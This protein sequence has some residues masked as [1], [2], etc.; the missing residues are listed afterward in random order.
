MIYVH[1]HNLKRKVYPKPFFANFLCEKKINK[2]ILFGYF[3][4]FTIIIPFYPESVSDIFF[5][6]YPWHIVEFS[7]I[8]L[9]FIVIYGGN[10]H[11]VSTI[12]HNCIVI[13]QSTHEKNIHTVYIN[14]NKWFFFP[15]LFFLKTW[16]IL[17]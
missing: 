7:S 1:F 4:I 14:I 2:K 16:T 3:S 15:S 5:M 8:N 12:D 9:Q 17:M 13:C 6:K 11:G 10:L